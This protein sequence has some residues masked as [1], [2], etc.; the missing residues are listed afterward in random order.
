[1][2]RSLRFLAASCLI[3]F[4]L[5]FIIVAGTRIHPRLSGLAPQQIAQLAAESGRWQ[6][7]HAVLAVASLLGLA[8]V[9]VIWTLVARGRS[10]PIALTA[11]VGAIV[12]AAGAAML[13]GVV[14]METGLVAPLAEACTNGGVCQA[15][16]NLAFADEFA[17]LG[18]L[19]V[20]P[21]GWAGIPLLFGI[22]LLAG[23]GWFLGPLRIWEAPILILS[24][25]GVLFTNPGFHGRAR[26][27]LMFLLIAMASL[28]TRVIRTGALRPSP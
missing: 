6:T 27:P 1:V 16:A 21:L 28:A 7:V 4:P 3:L 12:A 23:A 17:R 22:I 25:I 11:H 18:W 24:A 9:L 13:S 20:P 14:L 10:G 8:A 2:S 5:L 26:W 15:P 19:D